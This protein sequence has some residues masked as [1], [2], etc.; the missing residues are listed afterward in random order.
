MALLLRC[1]AAASL[2]ATT[3][4]FAVDF[5][6]KTPTADELTEALTPPLV[7]KGF[8]PSNTPGSTTEARATGVSMRIQFERGS[9][10]IRPDQKVKLANLAEAM[11]R[12]K[13]RAASFQAIGHTDSTGSANL[14]L[15]LS[16]DRA[17]AVIALL[18]GHGVDATRLHAE[19]KGPTEPLSEFPKDSPNQRRVEFVLQNP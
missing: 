6:D 16:K 9:A 1:I 5:G 12:E 18:V 13:L 8:R 11:N 15:R 3:A 17:N 14:N 7:S 19:G 2:L 10:R 4:A